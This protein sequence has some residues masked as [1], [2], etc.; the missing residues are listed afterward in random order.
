[1]AE[2]GDVIVGLADKPLSMTGSQFHQHIKL[3]YKVGDKLVLD[4]LRAGKKMQF[5]VPLVE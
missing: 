4:I 5:K 3:N 2:I 1:M